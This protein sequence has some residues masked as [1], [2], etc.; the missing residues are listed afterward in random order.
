P[1]EKKFGKRLRVDDAG[2]SEEGLH[3]GKEVERAA[4]IEAAETI[5][6]IERRNE[7]GP[8]LAIRLDLAPCFRLIPAQLLPAAALR[9]GAGTRWPPPPS[10]PAADGIDATD[11]SGRTP[12]CRRRTAPDRES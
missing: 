3:F 10:P 11:R 1:V 9:D 6:A 2:L 8:T 5:D 7:Q 12:A 4:R